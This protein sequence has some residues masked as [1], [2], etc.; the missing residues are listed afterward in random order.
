M[1]QLL[2]SEVCNAA[3]GD[4]LARGGWWV[5]WVTDD[6]DNDGGGGG[7]G[8]GGGLKALFV[9]KCLNHGSLAS[10]SLHACTHIS[11]DFTTRYD[12]IFII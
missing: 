5:P 4:E 1:L 3:E 12:T 2:S 11:C 9:Q 10:A 6:D 8:G 7:G